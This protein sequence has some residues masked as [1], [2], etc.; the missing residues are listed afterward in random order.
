MA[1]ATAIRVKP[2][3][4]RW[5]RSV[6]LVSDEHAPIE[7]FE[8]VSDP[9]DLDVVLAFE[10][11]ADPAARDLAGRLVAIPV[12]DRVHGPGSSDA[13]TPFLYYPP[14]GSRFT[15]GTFGVYCAA[16]EQAT[17][18]AE[19]AWHR[20]R[21]YAATDAPSTEI[22]MIELVASHDADVH[23][24]R[25]EADARS[26]LYHPDPARHGASQAFAAALR[27]RGSTGIVY[28]SVRRP[29][30]QCVAFFRPRS[31]GSVERAGR[32]GYLWSNE[33]RRITSAREIRPL[34]LPRSNS[35]E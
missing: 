7:I 29:G 5:S 21:L 30:G 15:D 13:M 12:E 26:E 17:A 35:L 3:R 10:A 23:D 9:S 6:R 11:L 19:S 2:S 27:S 25:G 28:D 1:R 14:E 31:V 22:P 8:R 18:V 32:L 16:R 4:L 20:A 33:E 24:I 34:D